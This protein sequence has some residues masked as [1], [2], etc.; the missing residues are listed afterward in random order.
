M[1]LNSTQL[2]RHACGKDWNGMASVA[3][4]FRVLII[5]QPSQVE[6]PSATSQVAGSARYVKQAKEILK[7]AQVWTANPLPELNR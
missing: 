3:S 7:N 6:Y 4:V 2:H 1:K 5:E